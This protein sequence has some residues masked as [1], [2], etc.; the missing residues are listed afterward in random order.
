[1]TEARSTDRAD[2]RAARAVLAAPASAALRVQATVPESA[3]RPVDLAGVSLV[4]DAGRPSLVCPADHPLAEAAAAGVPV[5]LWL[6]GA[7]PGDG[8]GDSAGPGSAPRLDLLGTLTAG[9]DLGSL[10]SL[11]LTLEQALLHRDSGT[12]S[13]DL[14]TFAAPDLGL[15]P[16]LLRRWCQHVNEAHGDVLR[17]VAARAA[18][19]PL[20]RIIAARLTDLDG[21]GVTLGWIDHGGAHQR[22]ISF[23]LPAESAED[24][25]PLLRDALGLALH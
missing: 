4:D 1:M 16:A 7:E 20:A 18:G 23:V 3:G 5:R 14:A 11:R 8:A 13:L 19:R 22:R 9:S 10:V 2:A 21:E 12:T 15:D 17:P 6:A 25:G 24:L